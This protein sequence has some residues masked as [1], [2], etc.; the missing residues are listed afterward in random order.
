MAARKSPP[1]RTSPSTIARYFFH[2]CERFLYYSSVSPEE[3]KR[4]GI[5]RPA[6]DQSPLVGAIL[7]SGYQWER[8][9]LE[10]LLRGKVVIAPGSGEL[11]T[12]RMSPEQTL[13][14]LR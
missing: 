2:D 3:R 10:R 7:E 9:V 4:R 5:P 6:F 8:E 1:F 11:H 12:R 14:C 13:D